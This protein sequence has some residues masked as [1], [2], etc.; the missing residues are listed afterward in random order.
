MVAFRAAFDDLAME[1]YAELTASGDTQHFYKCRGSAR[2]FEV[3]A[4]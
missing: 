1:R 2:G 3:L 4:C